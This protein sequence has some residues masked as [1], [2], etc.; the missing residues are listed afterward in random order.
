MSSTMDVG[1]SI[2]EHC[3]QRTYVE[4]VKAHYAA[5]IVSIEAFAMPGTSRVTEGKEAVLAKNAWWVANHEVRESSVEGPLP[6]GEDRFALYFTGVFTSKPLDNAVITMKEV[7]VYT[8]KDGQVVQ[9]EFF[10]NP[11]AL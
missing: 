7:A 4:A 11:P 8:V 5:D 9:E 3:R 10:Y 1:R 6:C 2:A